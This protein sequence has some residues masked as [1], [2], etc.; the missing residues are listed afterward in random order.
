MHRRQKVPVQTLQYYSR[1]IME[2]GKCIFFYKFS[3]KIW[4]WRKDSKTELLLV[5]FKNLDQSGDN[6]GENVKSHS[7]HKWRMNKRKRKWKKHTDSQ[8]QN[9]KYPQ[10]NYLSLIWSY[11]RPIFKFHVRTSQAVCINF[12]YLP[13]RKKKSLVANPKY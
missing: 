7:M 8:L 12:A 2:H 3:M 5:S 9:V 11:Q 6:E 1:K 13:E 10:N 4:K